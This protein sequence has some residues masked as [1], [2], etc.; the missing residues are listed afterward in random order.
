[1]FESNEEV[2]HCSNSPEGIKRGGVG[3]AGGEQ[4]WDACT[5]NRFKNLVELQPGAV[6]YAPID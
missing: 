5:K 2:K 4:G 1:M 6:Y 3:G